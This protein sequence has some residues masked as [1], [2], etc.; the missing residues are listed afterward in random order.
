MII[1]AFESINQNCWIIYKILLIID[2]D[3][4]M[5]DKILLVI[6]RNRLIIDKDSISY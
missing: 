5:I 4:S 6:D 3:H 1:R 2:K